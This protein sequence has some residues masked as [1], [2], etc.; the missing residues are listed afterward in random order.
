MPSLPLASLEGFVVETCS[1]MHAKSLIFG[2][3][4]AILLGGCSGQQLLYNATGVIY[5][6]GA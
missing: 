1:A 4:A 3:L 2:L 5:P 6:V